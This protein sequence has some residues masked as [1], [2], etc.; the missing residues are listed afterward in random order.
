ML[1]MVKNTSRYSS[2]HWVHAG[3]ARAHHAQGYSLPLGVCLLLTVT[4]VPQHIRGSLR[5]IYESGFSFDHEGPGAQTQ[6]FSL[7]RWHR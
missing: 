5:T 3:A 4:E 6:V 1:A 7:G 2:C